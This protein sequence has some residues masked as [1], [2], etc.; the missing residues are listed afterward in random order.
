MWLNKA[1]KSPEAYQKFLEEE[2]QHLFGADR[3]WIAPEFA[4]FT[5]ER[6]KFD[7]TYVVQNAIDPG[8]YKLE[9]NGDK[10]SMSMEVDAK[11]FEMDFDSKQ[12]FVRRDVQSAKNPLAYLDCC[13]SLMEGVDYAGYEQMVTLEDRSPEKKM[14]LEPWLLT[15]VNPNG[16]IIVPYSGKF[17]FVDYYDPIDDSI[18]KVEDG[19]IRLKTTG[20]RK[21]KTAYKAA[22]TFGRAAY[23]N[24]L[25]DGR[26]YLVVKSYYNDPSCPYCC[27][28]WGQPGKRGCSL[29]IYDDF[30]GNGGFTEFENAGTTI[31]LETG[32]TRSESGLSQ[33]FYIGER[34]QII[35]ILNVLL[36]ID[37]KAEKL[38]SEE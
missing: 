26:Y 5:E 8:N 29:Y 37:Y 6:L 12:F 28:P 36:N 15:Q 17:E 23:L 22:Q 7:D 35:K 32:R 3:L 25:D 14:Y 27:E 31:G 33:Y 20:A 24:K 10:I 19:Y 2:P 16:E 1:L 9:E 21:Y 38:M 30:G 4:F 18:Q 34:E 11:V 13:D